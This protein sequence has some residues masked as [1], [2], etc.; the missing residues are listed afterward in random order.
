MRV[1]GFT[2]IELLVVIAIIGT[3]SSIVLSALSTSRDKGRDAAIK[4]DLSQ[5]VTVN[6]LGRLDGN[7]GVAQYGYACSTT[8]STYSGGG[9]LFQAAY[10]Q[11]DKQIGSAMCAIAWEPSVPPPL[12]Q[13]IPGGP[14][15]YQ[16]VTAGTLSRSATGI[17]SPASTLTSTWAASVRLSTGQ[18]FCVDQT[19][20]ATITPALTVGASDF[21]C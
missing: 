19:N 4:Q 20:M 5:M 3:L 18:Y 10:A 11:S 16:I 15:L 13:A 12:P 21:N 17:S 1:R 14:F 2:L 8:P 6:E 7:A 9:S